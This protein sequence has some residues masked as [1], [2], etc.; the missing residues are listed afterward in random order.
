MAKLGRSSHFAIFLEIVNPL[1]ARRIAGVV[2]SL[3]ERLRLHPGA[4]ARVLE[5]KGPAV[6]FASRPAASLAVALEM[7]GIREAIATRLCS[8]TAYRLFDGA[9]VEEVVERLLRP[10]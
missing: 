6:P 2:M 9:A 4:L 7:S 3:P 5:L 1:K 8:Q 10:P